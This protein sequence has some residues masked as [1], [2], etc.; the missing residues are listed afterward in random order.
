MPPLSITNQ[1]LNVLFQVHQLLQ[2][3]AKLSEH[4]NGKVRGSLLFM[5]H[6]IFFSPTRLIF[7]VIQALLCKMGVAR[8]LRKLLQECSSMCYMEDNMIS[9]KGVYSNDLLMLRWKIPLLRS[10]AS[11]FSTRPSSK[12]PTTVEE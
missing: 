7:L 5:G 3:I 6:C 1:L 12:E 2:F 11:I 4:P 10:I 8:I 9:D